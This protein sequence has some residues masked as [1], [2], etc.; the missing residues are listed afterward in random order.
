MTN[1]IQVSTMFERLPVTQDAPLANGAGPLPVVIF[2]HGVAGN[3]VLYSHH[4][5][6]LAS[7]GFL[8]VAIEHSDGLGTATRLAGNR[9]AS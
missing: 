5:C 7:L 8:V 2:S 4:L 1:I 6:R 9:C 3:R